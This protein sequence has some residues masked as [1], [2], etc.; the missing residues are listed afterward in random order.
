M[1]HLEE[2]LTTSLLRTKR[3]KK[4]LIFKALAYF[5][6]CLKSSKAD[7]SFYHEKSAYNISTYIDA[8][9]KLYL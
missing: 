5:L 4:N 8:K 1:S 3:E 7:S 6:F 9:R 2:T